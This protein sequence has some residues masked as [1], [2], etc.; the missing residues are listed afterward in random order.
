MADEVLVALKRNWSIPS[1]K[2][3]VKVED[4]WVTLDGELTWN[5]QKEA[6]QHAVHY[7]VG[8]NGVDNNI[9]IKSG[10]NDAIE[11]KDIEHA[12]KRSTIDDSNIKVSVSDN[13][14]TLSGTVDSWYQKGEACRITWNTPGVSHVKNDL[15]IDYEIDFS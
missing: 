13:V 6:A 9:R 15:D 10:R 8:V 5:Y 7:L 3:S 2:I 12:L 1:E 14:V 4:G 11:K